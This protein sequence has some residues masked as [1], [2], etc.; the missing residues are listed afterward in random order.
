M[1]NVDKEGF[2]RDLTDWDKTVALQLAAQDQIELT[3]AHWEVIN[4]ARDYYTRHHISPVSRV[5]VSIVRRHLGPDKGQSIYLMKLFS[6]RPARFV[7]KIAGLPRPTNC[8]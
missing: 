6:G 2:L 3:A 5:L 7:S 8:D 1:L 4:I